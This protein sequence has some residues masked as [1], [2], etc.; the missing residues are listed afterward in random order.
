[1]R[2]GRVTLLSKP[3]RALPE[4]NKEVLDFL[5]EYQ[6]RNKDVQH[7]RILL[8]GPAAA[9]KSSFINSV[10]SS[11]LNRVTSRAL[12]DSISARS[13]SKRYK[14]FKIQKNPQ[15]LYSFVFNDIMGFDHGNSGVCV[16][17]VK[18]VMKGHITENYKFN[19]QS[20]LKE[21]DPNYKS[22]P[23]LEDR[24]HVLVCVYPA[25]S[26]SIMPKDI[27]RQM[28]EVRLAASDMG[29][30]QLAIITKVDEACPAAGKNINNV[31]KSKYLKE[32][33]D[34][35]HM[36]LGIPHNRIFLVK[37]YSKEM[38]TEAGIDALILYALEQMIHAGEDFLNS[39]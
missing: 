33:V 24:V 18:L 12:T 5:E 29:I 19:P 26:V 1:M 7:I 31:Y 4:N 34:E 15:G 35:F 37:N 14:T 16:E 2:K 21:N 20:Q 6:P 36:A 10:E 23:T 27:L 38:E 9:A 8:H 17:D 11:L 28:R 32:K 22:S 39:L 3:W 13:F 25:S 30:P